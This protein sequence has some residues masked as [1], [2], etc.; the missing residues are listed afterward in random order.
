MSW[1]EDNRRRV[2]RMTGGRLAYVYLPVTAGDGNAAFLRQFYG[3]SD[4]K[5][6]IID[7]RG[8]G[9]GRIADSVVQC[10]GEPVHAYIS[11]REGEPFSS[12]EVVI[13][14]PKVLVID[15]EAASGGD[16]L[17]YLFRRAG[18]G[19][20]IGK[21]TEGGFVGV[22]GLLRL[23]DG[24][25]VS[26]PNNAPYSPEGRWLPENEGVAPDIDV[27]QDPAAVRAGHDPQP[28][29]AIEV[30]MAALKKTRPPKVARP[31]Y[32]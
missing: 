9:G 4:K 20:L 24:G 25:W 2:D 7:E 28:E 14:G 1:V 11:T 12:P 19:P 30:V 6:V 26:A 27:E 13:P 8:D 23:I 29:E 21:R 18:L 17:P 3:Q 16:I 32:R 15:G 5:A 10:L 31:P 22:G